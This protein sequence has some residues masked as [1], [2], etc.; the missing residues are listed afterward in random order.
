MF[1]L[2][3][4]KGKTKE[5]TLID[6]YTT[7]RY[8]VHSRKTDRKHAAQ[9]DTIDVTS[10]R[11]SF[12]VVMPIHRERIRN[13]CEGCVFVLRDQQRAHAHTHRYMGNVDSL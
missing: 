10:I 6:S 13:A 11:N 1:A 9:R 7:R 12:I 5:E 8:A 2:H 4:S 3:S